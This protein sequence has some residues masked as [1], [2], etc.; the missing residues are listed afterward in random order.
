LGGRGRQISEFKASLV[1][2]LSLLKKNGKAGEIS[3]LRALT[4]FPEIPEFNSQQPHGGIQ[5]TVMAFPGGLKKTMFFFLR[6]KQMC[7]LR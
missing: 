1:L 5:P 7:T 6:I 2:L 4:A 3:S